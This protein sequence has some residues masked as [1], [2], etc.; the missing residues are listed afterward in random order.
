MYCTALFYVYMNAS[1][2]AFKLKRLAHFPVFSLKSKP[3]CLIISCRIS[4][5]SWHTRPLCLSVI[6]TH[7][8]GT[9]H[10][11]LCRDF[12]KSHQGHNHGSYHKSNKKTKASDTLPGITLCAAETPDSALPP[13]QKA[14]LRNPRMRAAFT[15]D[16]LFLAQNLKIN[17]E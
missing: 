14:P 3:T 10:P 8:S 4:Y 9:S 11:T 7:Q 2:T 5:W 16:E 13:R 17:H 6:N 15:S 1:Q 12:P